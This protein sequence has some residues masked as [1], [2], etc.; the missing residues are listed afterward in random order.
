MNLILF[1]RDRCRRAR[2]CL[3]QKLGIIKRVHRIE[4]IVP[5][6]DQACKARPMA[7]DPKGQSHEED[8]RHNTKL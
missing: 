1:C 8:R 3:G 7:L 5:K 4:F 6:K 2:G